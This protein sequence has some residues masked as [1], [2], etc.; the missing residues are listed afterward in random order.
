MHPPRQGS[1]PPRPPPRATDGTDRTATTRGTHS[2]TQPRE[3]ALG[4][5]LQRGSQSRTEECPL[6]HSRRKGPL[7]MNIYTRHLRECSVSVGGLRAPPA[8]LQSE[9]QL[10]AQQQSVICFRTFSRMKWLF[11]CVPIHCLPLKPT[12]CPSFSQFVVK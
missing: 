3:V 7:G 5:R 6:A 4:D 1:I 9:L 2:A 10:Q 12:S 8:L 11:Q